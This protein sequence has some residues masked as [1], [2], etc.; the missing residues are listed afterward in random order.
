MFPCC[1]TDHGNSEGLAVEGS[2]M[3]EELGPW[4][5]HGKDSHSK[6]YASGVLFEKIQT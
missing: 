1:P 2:T 4:S 5:L 3:C 6:Y